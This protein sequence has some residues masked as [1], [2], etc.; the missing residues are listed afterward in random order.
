MISISPPRR[1]HFKYGTVRF[2]RWLCQGRKLAMQPIPLAAREEAVLQIFTQ[3]A[4]VPP[5]LPLLTRRLH[6][7][8]SHRWNKEC[9]CHVE[10]IEVMLPPHHALALFLHPTDDF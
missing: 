1:R 9:Y 7:S 10:V 4:P 6:F 3:K 8:L 5:P 2:L